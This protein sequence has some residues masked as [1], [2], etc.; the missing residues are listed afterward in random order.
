MFYKKLT[1]KTNKERNTLRYKFPFWNKFYGGFDAPLTHKLDYIPEQWLAFGF[2]ALHNSL[3]YDTQSLCQY[4]YNDTSQVSLRIRNMS[5]GHD[6]L[7]PTLE[8]NF[9]LVQREHVRIFLLYKTNSTSKIGRN[10]IIF[11]IACPFYNI[12]LATNTRFIFK[13]IAR[14]NRFCENYPSKNDF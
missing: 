13:G 4:Y 10:K 2:S 8:R 12:F 3:V 9:D 14:K 1:K 6:Q 11:K 7:F 5:W